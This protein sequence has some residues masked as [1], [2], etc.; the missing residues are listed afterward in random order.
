M[1]ESI[2]SRQR[3]PIRRRCW[4][5]ARQV[6]T[7]GLD[8]QR[9]ILELLERA[10]TLSVASSQQALRDLKSCGARIALDD[11]G[12]AY[13]VL[14]VKELPVDMI[15]LDRSFLIG[16][17]QQ[18][19]E[20]RFLMNLVHLAQALGLGWSPKALNPPPP[21]MRSPL[22]AYSL[23][24]G[25][26]IARPMPLEDL[27]NWL[28]QYRPAPWSRPT[29]VLGAVALQLRGLD[30]SGRILEQRPSFLQHLLI[31]G[32]DWEQQIEASLGRS[33]FRRIETGFRA[34]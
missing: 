3:W 8:P 1:S 11:V 33:G 34:P 12:S 26:S 17:E 22:S 6:E 27:L 23:A 14:R 9:I 10:D 15:K 28:K 18:P 31:A 29:S 7:S 2:L 24:Q 19:K 5:C 21:A 4:T 32:A 16:L 13:F 30:A 25:Y 20:L